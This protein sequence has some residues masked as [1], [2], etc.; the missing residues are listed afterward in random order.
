M[1]VDLQVAAKGSRLLRR[2]SACGFFAISSSS[3]NFAGDLRFYGE[4]VGPK[5]CFSRPSGKY[6]YSDLLPKC[7]I[8]ISVDAY[9]L[10]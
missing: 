4:N 2:V 5:T 8:F 9:A 6:F 3:R 10:N 7:D 1:K